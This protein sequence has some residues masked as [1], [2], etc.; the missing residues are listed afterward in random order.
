MATARDWLSTLWKASYKG[1]PFWVETDEEAG[2]RRVVIHDIPMGTWFLEDLG[3]G[4]RTFTVTAYLA[5]D[6]ADTDA[7]GLIATCA[8]IGPGVLVLPTHG[9]LLVR[10][11][12]FKRR[13]DKDR[14]GYIAVD[15]NFIKE[16]VSTPLASI[17]QLA[18]LVFLAADSLSASISTAF[19]GGVQVTQQ[20]DYV[21]AAAS[22][23]AQN[24]VATLEAI[25]T[26]A[27]V[28]PA[29]SVVQAVAL[30]VQFDAIPA[31]IA[32][33]TMIATVPDGVVTSARALGD[34]MP[35]SS[36]VSVFEAIVSD[37]TL[38]APIATVFPTNNLRLATVNAAQAKRL[39]LLAALTAYCEGIA[40]MTLT[41][42]PSAITL[43]ANVAEYVDAILA[44]MTADDIDIFNA[45][46]AMRDATVT[47]LSRSIIDL[48]PVL[49]IEANMSLPSLY[50]A[51]RLYQDPT[52]STELVERNGVVHPSLMPQTFEALGR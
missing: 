50:W 40:R 45:V 49:T 23:G 43:R 26:T 38:S 48:A 14:H 46:L 7:A 5:S 25:R 9:P 21:T 28:D 36:A 44:G 32:D 6:N 33:P 27:P 39:L 30:Q 47:Y 42:R 11:P 10:C 17:A 41:E 51:W 29:V 19:V 20:A 13:R 16:G 1:T 37:P 8:T 15:M 3:E 31:A 2:S 24:A 18:N 52:R 4:A 22:G 35:A 34:A 12:K